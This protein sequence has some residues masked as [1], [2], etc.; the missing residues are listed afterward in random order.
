MQSAREL[1]ETNRAAAHSYSRLMNKWEWAGIGVSSLVFA[2]SFTQ[3]SIPKFIPYASAIPAVIFSIAETYRF[4]ARNSRKEAE[5]EEYLLA[6]W[7]KD[8]E[9]EKTALFRSIRNGH[10]KR[11]TEL[12]ECTYRGHVNTFEREAVLD[13]HSY[14]KARDALKNGDYTDTELYDLVHDVQSRD[15]PDNPN[16]GYDGWFGSEDLPIIN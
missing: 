16:D 12:A 7:R 14:S 6:K 11:L 5:R 2:A 3:G 8:V 15:Y 10:N 9:N 4:A 13:D 1:A